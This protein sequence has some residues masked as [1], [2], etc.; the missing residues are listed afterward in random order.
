MTREE[1]IH[2][3]KTTKDWSELREALAVLVPELT[4]SEDDKAKRLILDLP[5]KH[6]ADYK[7]VK[8]WLEKPKEQ[9]LVE[10]GEEDNRLLDFWL[11]V[12]DRNDWR[13]DGDFCKAS[14]EFINRLKSQHPKLHW[15]PSE[16]QMEVLFNAERLVRANNYTENARIL[17]GLYDDL[18]KL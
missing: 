2:I 9:E 7:F 1:A 5:F 3:V 11:D 17:A 13:M 10:C 18:K 16:E 12:I 6:E 14:R 15:K 8:D 4:E